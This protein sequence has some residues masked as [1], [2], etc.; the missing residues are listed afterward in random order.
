MLTINSKIVVSCE[1]ITE[2][3]SC[4]SS[5]SFVH[6]KIVLERCSIIRFPVLSSESL[7]AGDRLETSVI[8]TLVHT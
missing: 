3:C 7:I 2:T 6:Q 5:N 1:L 4:A 8:V